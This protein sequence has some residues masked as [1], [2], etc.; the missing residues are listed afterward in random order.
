[1][2]HKICEL[3]DAR[4]IDQCELEAELRLAENRISKWKAGQGEPT[5]RQL[6]KMA[7]KLN[8]SVLYLLEDTADQAFPE[9]TADELYLIRTF[10][11]LRLD[12]DV[13][14]RRMCGLPTVAPRQESVGD[15]QSAKLKKGRKVNGA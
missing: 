5:A 6:Y 11:S 3:L 9:I 15:E 10:R 7:R 1:M 8:V 4:G 12:V 2:I 14:V 13:A